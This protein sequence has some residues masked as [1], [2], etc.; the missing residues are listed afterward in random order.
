MARIG[1]YYIARSIH[2]HGQQSRDFSEGAGGSCSGHFYD[3]VVAGIGDVNRSLGVDGDRQGI[4]QLAG[5]G[6][7]NSGRRDF[8][9]SVVAGVGNV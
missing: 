9:D 5:D 8:A 1:S 6:R 7:D 3:A 2:R 4:V